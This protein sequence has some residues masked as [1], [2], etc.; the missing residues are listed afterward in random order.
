MK[1]IRSPFLIYT[2][3][4]PIWSFS[5]YT[6]SGDLT[7]KVYANIIL[8][9]RES[10]VFNLVKGTTQESFNIGSEAE[11]GILTPALAIYRPGGHFWEVEI[12]ALGAKRVDHVRIGTITGPFPGRTST[13]FLALRYGYHFSLLGRQDG[14]V[15]PYIGFSSTPFLE[16]N[17][18]AP[19]NQVLYNIREST[20]GLL[21]QVC[22]RL[23]FCLTDYL[24]LDFNVLITAVELTN[25]SLTLESSAVNYSPDKEINSQLRWLPGRTLIRLGAGVIF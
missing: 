3:F 2:L 23:N 10:E 8:E 7:L 17:H 13:F 16:I 15:R 12:A 18:T 11:F 19:E 6:A 14:V 22:P 25:R 1:I 4:I 5:Q 21:G 20:F 9:Q 24:L